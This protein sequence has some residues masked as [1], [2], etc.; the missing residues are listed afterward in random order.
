MSTL[1]P[2][3]NDWSRG[4][5]VVAHPDDMEYG[6]S[7]AVARWTT[8]GKEITYVLVTRGEA[9]I[10]DMDRTLVRRI[11]TTE[12]A[13]AC[14]EVGAER[15]EWLDHTDG[16][17]EYGLELRRELARAIRRHRPEV[18]LS[19]NYR[20][21]WGG[22][23]FNM[24][25]HRN[26]GLALMDAARDA[27]NRWIFPQLIDRG[28]EPWDGVRFAAFAGSPKATHAV[29]VTGYL[30]DGIRSLEAHQTYLEYLG[31]EHDAKGDLTRRAEGVGQ[32]I[33]TEHGVAFEVIWL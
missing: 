25:D 29:D 7:S 1:Q 14:K 32:N 2:L 23:F 27:A 30:A 19:I 24:A 11:R 9:G 17:I 31:S 8:E 10:G 5:V 21:T 33:G 12:Q 15:L 6:S 18:L 13:N 28:F 16:V 22:S 26:V 20:E 3:P 4:M